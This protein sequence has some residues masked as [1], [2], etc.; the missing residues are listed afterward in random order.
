MTFSTFDLH[1]RETNSFSS[2][3][4]IASSI[5]AS[6]VLDVQR[7]ASSGGRSWYERRMWCSSWLVHKGPEAWIRSMELG[8]WIGATIS[9]RRMPAVYWMD[10]LRSSKIG[11]GG[12][13]VVHCI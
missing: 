10:G 13:G 8:A 7:K 5:I 1:E 9:Y 6:I 11:C 12:N 3:I 2:V 4:F